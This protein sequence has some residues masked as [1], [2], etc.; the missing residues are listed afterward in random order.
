MLSWSQLNQPTCRLCTSA[1][2]LRT[3]PPKE[4]PDAFLKMVKLD[5]A[6]LEK[7]YRS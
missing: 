2:V 4:D 6:V 3:E 5:I 7:A 1:F